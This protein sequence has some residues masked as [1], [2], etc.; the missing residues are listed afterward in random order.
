MSQGRGAASAL[1]VR[2]RARTKEIIIDGIVIAGVIGGE[3]TGE[4]WVSQRC[5][6]KDGDGGEQDAEGA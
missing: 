4:W 2:A 1:E 6:W 3:E 5:Y